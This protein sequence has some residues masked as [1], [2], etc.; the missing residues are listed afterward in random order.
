MDYYNGGY[1]DTGYYDTSTVDTANSIMGG[2][3]LA[4]GMTALVKKK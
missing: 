4:S 1:Y 3:V 2:V